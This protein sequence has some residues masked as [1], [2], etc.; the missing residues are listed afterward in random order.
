MFLFGDPVYLLL[1]I[2]LFLLLL[3]T[4]VRCAHPP[5]YEPP[6]LRFY[7][8]VDEAATPGVVSF[9]PRLWVLF[10]AAFSSIVALSDPEVQ[11][12]DLTLSFSSFCISFALF[13]FVVWLFLEMRAMQRDRD[14]YR[15]YASFIP[16]VPRE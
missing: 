10:S 13:L 16:R 9:D 7:T 8:R 4:I 1:G 14:E 3:Y 12:A 11:L 2:P 15:R 5:V 6:S